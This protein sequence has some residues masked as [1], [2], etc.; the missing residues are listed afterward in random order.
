MRSF[1][2]EVFTTHDVS[3]PLSNRCDVCGKLYQSAATLRN[4]QS[5]VHEEVVGAVEMEDQAGDNV[6][7]HTRQLIKFLLMKRE[8]DDAI[9]AGDGDRL[10]L[11]IKCIF[12]LFKQYGKHK[13]ALAC[14]EYIAQIELFLSPRRACLVKHERFVNMSGKAGANYPMNQYAEHVNKWLKDHFTLYQGKLSQSSLDCLT[15]AMDE[16][17]SILDN[18]DSQFGL[19]LRT[20]SHRVDKAAYRE[21][22]N[23]AAKSLVPH[24]LFGN[25]SRKLHSKKL[26]ESVS[27]S[28]NRVDL[29]ALKDWL[30]KRIESMTKDTFY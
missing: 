1:L 30:V 16:A 3:L 5:T 28:L 8:M 20:G 22:V 29:Y 11:V 17:K 15:K 6:H 4:H 26:N 27:E 2:R 10:Y 12:I 24:K 13:Y 7:A 21:D 19:E 25:E 23:K 14:Q 9:K 18:H